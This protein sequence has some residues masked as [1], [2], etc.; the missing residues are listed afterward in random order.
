MKDERR[1]MLR[2]FLIGAAALCIGVA[3]AGAL[4]TL[5]HFLRT[6]RSGQADYKQVVSAP[7]RKN[8]RPGK[9]SYG[10]FI[11]SRPGKFRFDYQ[12]PFRQILVADGKK[13]WLHDVEL[14]QVTVR[15]QQ[16][17]LGDTPAAIVTATDRASLEKRFTFFEEPDRDGQQW[18][19]AEPK[20]ADATVRQV[21][22]GFR[23]EGEGDAR[24]PVLR[25]LEI[26]DRFGQRSTLVF[27]HF[28]LNAPLPENVFR[29]TVPEGVSVIEQ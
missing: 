24:Q 11:F 18:L 15:D 22:V 3:H 21:R 6:A 5:D 10:K 7:E 1:G 16:Q 12:K 25:T 23:T 2:N 13:I 28:R 19:R 17:A 29:F 8:A 26:D 27:D 20:T 14:D 9:P 4:E